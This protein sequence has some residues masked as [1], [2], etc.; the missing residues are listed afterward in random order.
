MIWSEVLILLV[1]LFQINCAKSNGHRNLLRVSA[2]ISA[3]NCDVHLLK[4]SSMKVKGS[5]FLFLLFT[6]AH[7]KQSSE[8][9]IIPAFYLWQT[10]ISLNTAKN[11]Y[12]DSLHCQ[13]LYLKF[14]DIGLDA[15]SQSATPLADLN[16]LTAA[17]FNEKQIVPTVFITNE[18]FK[19]VKTREEIENLAQKTVKAIFQI[20]AQLP[21]N[22]YSEIQFDC[23]WTATTREAYFL[24]LEKIKN[25]LPQK[26]QL[27]AT[28]RLHQYKFPTKTGIPPVQRGMLMFYN[29]GDIAD[30][31]TENSIF[32]VTD[33]E[34]Y[35]LGAPE[36]YPLPLDIALPLFSWAI[37][38]RE[39]VF[40][41]IINNPNCIEV[42][43]NPNFQKKSDNRY[44]VT[45][46]TLLEGHYLRP[47]DWI[48][49]EST[50]KDLLPK[51]A[52]LAQKI[53]KSTETTVAFFQLD[54]QTM[55]RF[56][57]HFLQTICDT[58]RFSPK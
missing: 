55:Q 12:L 39:G 22:Q 37:V 17:D 45:T 1:V 43:N 4:Q 38:Y 27:S 20:G 56:S 14:L 51:I 3:I 28:I 30:M 35:I 40:W 15:T 19:K 54:T 36:N 44:L 58:L 53:P 49:I 5:F 6:F 46:S 32:E 11:N 50:D 24:F 21:Q 52:N 13:K 8:K 7:C 41:K 18:T 33:A 23:D 26:T 9:I 48:K 25:I 29:T 10:E 47:E 34:K 31:E 2:I 42:Q 57:P 16:I